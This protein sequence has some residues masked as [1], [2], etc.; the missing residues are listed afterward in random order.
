MISRRIVI[1]GLIVILAITLVKLGNSLLDEDRASVDDEIEIISSEKPEIEIV[2]DEGVRKTVFYFKDK[3]GYLVPVMKRIPWEEGIAKTTI[4]NMVD[5]TELREALAN[6]GLSP[7]IPMGTE[8]LGMAI[9]QDTGLCKIDFS[10]EIQNVET[11]KDEENLIKGIVYTLTEFPTIKRVQ[12]MVEGKIIPVLRN[13][14]AIDSPLERANINL[15]GREDEGSSKVMVYYKGGEDHNEYFIPLTIPT[16]APIANVHT[17][18][19]LLFQGPPVETG[20]KTDIPSGISLQGVEIKDGTAFVDINTEG[21]TGLE[22]SGVLDDLMKNVGLTLSQF[23]EIDSVELLLDGT[24][25]NS[26]IPV[27]AN[28]Y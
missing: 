16:M 18:L 4:R 23:E 19:E 26:S 27:F 25:V 14:V 11:E 15:I 24:A 13:S 10:K 3:D 2:E 7:L 8:V 1:I 21:I 5:S 12:I 17:A 22:N 9:D 20:L 6:T 28:E